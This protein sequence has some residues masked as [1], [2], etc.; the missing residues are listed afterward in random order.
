MTGEIKHEIIRSCYNFWDDTK[1]PMIHKNIF[2]ELYICST[3][4]I[5]PLLS[6]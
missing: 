5:C 3:Y 1:I 4:N 2:N 6:T